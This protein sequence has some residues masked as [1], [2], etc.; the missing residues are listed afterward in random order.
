MKRN[1]IIAVALVVMMMVGAVVL[2]S[3][4]NCPGNVVCSSGSVSSLC[5]LNVTSASDVQ[6]AANCAAYKDYLVGKSGTEC[7]C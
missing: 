6:E 2:M 4:S 5:A 7:D 3:C 1:K